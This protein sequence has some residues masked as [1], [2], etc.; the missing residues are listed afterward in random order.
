MGQEDSLQVNYHK[1]MN[2]TEVPLFKSFGFDSEK[3][4][5]LQKIDVLKR[6]EKVTNGK[7]YLEVGGKLLEDPHAARVLPGFQLDTKTKILQRLDTPF[8]IVYCLIYGD[9][10]KNR[11]LN[12]QKEEYIDTAITT[13]KK[14]EEIFGVK[15]YVVINNIPEQT[16]SLFVKGKEKLETICEHIYLRYHIDGYPN[17]T[18]RIL[19]SDGYGKDEEIPVQNKLVIVTG[20]AS[21]SGKMSTC[22]GMIYFDHL[23][24]LNSGYAKY[25]TFPVWNLPLEHPINLAYEA[26]TADIG[27]R[28]IID[29]YHLKEYNEVSVNY[30]RD[31]DAFVILKKLA[32]DLLPPNNMLNNYKSPTD[33]GMNHVKESI[34]NDEIVCIASLNEIRRREDWYQE[35]VN[36]GLGEDSWVRACQELERKALEYIQNKGYNP[37]LPL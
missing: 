23:N 9:I 12:N 19:S 37:T 4:I 18:Q 8:D 16:D 1:Y 34:T 14:M 29:E 28:N 10:I 24:G 22:F 17:D 20:A 27:D 11:Q 21:N 15:P 25:E 35:V 33:M 31:I 6:L 7:L 3:Y 32:S 2:T 5:E 36:N 26:A 13:I 30:N